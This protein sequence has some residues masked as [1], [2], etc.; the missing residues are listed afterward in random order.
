MNGRLRGTSVT[1][2]LIHIFSCLSSATVSRSCRGVSCSGGGIS[3]V[4]SASGLL[5]LSLIHIYLAEKTENVLQKRK[6]L[7]E[8]EDIC[9]ALLAKR[10]Y[11]A[12][13]YHTIIK[14]KLAIL[15]IYLDE[16]ELAPIE[17]ISK[18]IEK[19]ISIATQAFPEETFILEA[20]ANFNT[21][22]NLSLIHI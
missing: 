22:M 3:L 15:K 6:Y 16:Q 18:E 2:S 14:S 7:Q 19:Y 12:H 1:L 20:N 4:R 13:P 8:T 21:L 11:T 10:V 5:N 17:K 9:K